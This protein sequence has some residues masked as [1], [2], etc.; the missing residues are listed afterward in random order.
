MANFKNAGVGELVIDRC[1]QDSCGYTI[2]EIRAKVNAALKIDGLP[3]VQS[4][5][6]IRN[7]IDNIG[8]RYKTSIKR[9]KR[10][11]AI[12]YSYKDPNFS[13]FDGQLT[14][15]ELRQIGSVLQTVMFL[16]AYQGS[17]IY[18]E[19]C[20]TLKTILHIDGYQQP[21]LIYENI[22][23]ERELNHFHTL[24]DCIRCRVPVKIMHFVHNKEGTCHSTV[25]PYFMRQHQRKWHLLGNDHYEQK[26][27]CLAL[28]CMISIEKDYETT[29]M[30]GHHIS[31]KEFCEALY[32]L[33]NE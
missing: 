33:G 27:K 32:R 28:E 17:I 9:S 21:I 10:R 11:Q 31:I 20:S 18:R 8:N 7:D 5:N 30:P 25:H 19:L 15:G 6:T 14:K 4:C 3:L 29:F 2:E 1:L 23:S 26:A 12:V 24:Y 16:D 22:P 13:I